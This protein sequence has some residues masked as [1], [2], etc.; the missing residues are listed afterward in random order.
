MSVYAGVE[1]FVAR[2]ADAVITTGPGLA[3]QVRR[4]CGSAAVHAISDIPSSRVEPGEEGTRRARARLQQDPG[5]VLVVYVGS[6]AA[7]QGVDLMFEAM[8][9]VCRRWPRARF[10]V[11]G[12]TAQEIAARGRMLSA[13]G[14]AGR[15]T[16]AGKIPPDE[17]PDVLAAADI[18]LSPRMGG[19]NTPLKLLDYLKA[20]RAI[21][22]TDVPANRLILDASTAVFVSPGA[23][24]LAEGIGRL[25]E[26][27]EQRRALG[28]RA[29]ALYEARYTFAVFRDAL[30]RCYAACLEQGA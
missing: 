18:L 2:H 14:I 8:P 19:V 13:E 28:A 25:V 16:F 26:N 4:T 21:V 24:E 15:V 29:R 7:Y 20:G 23:A 12:G 6:F 5:D 17:L 27:P 1:R 22:A 11:V 9:A 30:A 10:V 3:D